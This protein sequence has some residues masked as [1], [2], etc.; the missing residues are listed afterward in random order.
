[1]NLLHKRIGI[2]GG[3]QLGKMM[4]LE[5]KRLGL[6]VVV[7]DPD[8]HCPAASICD[9]LMVADLNDP[10]G[11]DALAQ[12]VDVITYEWE[13]INA[14]ALE[15]LE[16]KGH[17]IYPTPKSLRVIQN[18]FLQNKLLEENGIPVPRFER[19]DSV[20]DIQILA[21]GPFGYPLVL[22]TTT[23][24]Y[25]GK[26]VWLIKDEAQVRQA[27]DGLGGGAVALM[28]EEFVAFDKEISVITCRGADGSR[29]LYPI[30]ENIHTHNVLDTTLA[31][32]RINAPTAQQAAD[33][34]DRV[35]QVFEGVGTFGIELFVTQDG[36]V[37]VNEVA[38]RPHNSGHFT[39]EACFANQFENHVRAV[40]GLPLGDTRLIT[41][42]VMVNLLGEG[43]GTAT[44]AGIHQAYQSPNVRVHFYGKPLSKTGRKMGHFTVTDT[45]VEAALKQALHLK[46]IVRIIGKD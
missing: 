12:R 21:N 18:K 23:G 17:V 13:Q 44:L 3:G 40:V 16:A 20:Q 14:A 36:R 33:V 46:K 35:M 28:A 34:A 24:G 30:A 1:M 22:K 8:A 5:A 4:I 41:P 31:P 39:I 7:L 15:T 26:G 37:L 2:V 19:V 45:T 32:A 38:P 27:F 43:S 25:D 6:Y 29:V 42:A 9:E 11:Y 10:T